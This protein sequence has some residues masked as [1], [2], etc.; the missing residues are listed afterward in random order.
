MRF[1]GG[2]VMTVTTQ[3]TTPGNGSAVVESRPGQRGVMWATSPS[4]K[5]GPA[6]RRP[7]SSAAK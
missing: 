4:R 6:P 1:P 5:R 2:N 3:A 7:A